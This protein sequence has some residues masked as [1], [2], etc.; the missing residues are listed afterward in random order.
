VVT[1]QWEIAARLMAEPATKDYG[2]LSV[3]VQSLAEVSLVRRLPPAVFWPRPAVDSAIVQIRPSA[4]G[5]A[6]V[7][8]VQRFR[9]FLRDLYAHRRKNLRGALV[10]MAGRDWTK[11]DVDARL[12]RLGIDGSVR[13]ETLDRTQHLRLCGEFG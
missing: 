11:A 4:A 9:N 6:A 5:R 1:V 12:D 3:L 8:D 7:G 10:A 2:A 13:A